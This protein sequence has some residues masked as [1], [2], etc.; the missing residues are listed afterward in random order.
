MSH[1]G[2]DCRLFDP[3][4]PSVPTWWEWATS[5]ESQWGGAI[6]ANITSLVY[7]DVTGALYIGT[8]DVLNV[9]YPNA[10]I[11]RVDGF[12]GLPYGNITSLS[13]QRSPVFDRTILHIGTVYG[14]IAADITP[15]VAIATDSSGTRLPRVNKF[16]FVDR[17]TSMYSSTS[18][19][20]LPPNEW[21][22]SYRFLERWLPGVYVS[23][24]ASHGD[25]RVNGSP[26]VLV[27]TRDGPMPPGA[28]YK[29][30]LSGCGFALYEDQMWTLEAKNARMTAI[31]VSVVCCC[32][33]LRSTLC[34]TFVCVCC[35]CQVR[36]D[37]HAM[38]AECDL[39]SFGDP[40]TCQNNGYDSDNTGSWT[41]K[42]LTAYVLEWLTTKSEAALARAKHFYYSGLKLLNTITGITVS[43]AWFACYRV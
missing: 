5:I 34:T 21:V 35:Y 41:A 27:S 23:G 18:Y 28:S 25:S 36:H 43:S 17:T 4:S 16:G 40:S 39:T 10:S 32:C 11:G 38:V 2:D 9:R 8:L 30:A 6:A 7:D 20:P 31:Q 26:F 37:R 33:C 24:I 42:T 14:S 29:S 12:V 15:K 22:W 1:C 19:E 13:L 3:T